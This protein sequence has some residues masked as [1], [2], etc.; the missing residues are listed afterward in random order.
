MT[1]ATKDSEVSKGQDGQIKQVSAL[2]VLEDGINAAWLQK[3][4][5]AKCSLEFLESH[6]VK[7]HLTLNAEE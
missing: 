2:Y 3:S 4:N 1:F 5:L 7:V 6:V